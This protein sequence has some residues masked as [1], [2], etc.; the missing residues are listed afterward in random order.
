[1]P[2]LLRASIL[3]LPTVLAD[4]PEDVIHFVVR[5]IQEHRPLLTTFVNPASISVADSNAAY[6]G[7]L[8]EFDL[9]LPDGI[10]FAKAAQ[11]LSGRRA[12]RV[13]FDSTSLAP[14]VLSALA[15]ERSS[16]V[17]V[18]GRPG[19]AAAAARCL[20]GRFP[21][22]RVI[23][24]LDGYGDM[25]AKA[26]LISRRAPDVVICGMG[27]GAQEE[28]LLRLRAKGW[29]GFGFTCGGYLDQLNGG[30][31]YYPLVADRLH[32][33]WAYRIWREPRRLGRRYAVQYPRFFAKLIASLIFE[34]RT[35]QVRN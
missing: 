20:V 32:L 7:S 4:E 13:S 2:A 14:P 1:M 31:Q 25:D 18:G 10:G 23:D 33:R 27:A 26:D 19:V 8:F 29:K 17:L 3:G 15:Y 16:I 12:A 11:W 21:T 22:L 30:F 28:L 5:R 9:V 6:R 35:M 34:E 24:A